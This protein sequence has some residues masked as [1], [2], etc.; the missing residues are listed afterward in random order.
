VRER[1]SKEKI[2]AFERVLAPPGVYLA[3]TRRPIAW[4]VFEAD[5]SV[6]RF[7]GNRGVWPGRLGTTAPRWRDTITTLLNAGPII[8]VRVEHRFWLPSSLNPKHRSRPKLRADELLSAVTDLIEQRA[9]EQGLPNLHRSYHDLGADLNFDAFAQ[10]IVGIAKRLGLMAWTDEDVSFHI[11]RV[12]HAAFI[13]Q[14]DLASE[15][16]ARCID[17]MVEGELAKLFPRHKATSGVQ[18]ARRNGSSTARCISG[19]I[20]T[21]RRLR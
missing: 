8:E 18:R 10:E 20:T 16:F 9:E 19:R 14:V 6:D 5:G 17:G 13:D 12:L 3:V 15:E 4:A 7:G 21:G 1:W 2:F 11:D